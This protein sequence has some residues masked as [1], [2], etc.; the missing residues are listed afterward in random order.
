MTQEETAKPFSMTHLNSGAG[1][2]AQGE[3]SLNNSVW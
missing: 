3:G 1:V 2:E